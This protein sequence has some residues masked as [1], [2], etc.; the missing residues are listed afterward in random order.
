MRV[1][2]CD[3]VVYIAIAFLFDQ[4]PC[5]FS[6]S[7]LMV[8]I[9][10]SVQRVLAGPICTAKQR[11]QKAAWRSTRADERRRLVKSAPIYAVDQTRLFAARESTARCA[12]YA[13]AS[14][15]R[16]RKTGMSRCEA[17]FSQQRSVVQLMSRS[18]LK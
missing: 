14:C 11:T 7:R 13:S 10:V 2:E 9:D 1:E 6:C 5:C 3:Y 18:S 4:C 17:Y 15:Q 16:A 8:K 12:V